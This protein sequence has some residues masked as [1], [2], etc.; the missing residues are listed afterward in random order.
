MQIFGINNYTYTPSCTPTAFKGHSR[1]LEKVLDKVVNKNQISESEK[2]LII[3]KI[4]AALCD[5][6]SASR[7]IGEGSHNA[8]YKI[9][10]KYAARIPLNEKIIKFNTGS[11]SV[12]GE[13]KFTKLTNFFGEAILNLGNLQIL[14]NVSPHMPAGVPEHIAKKCGRQKV[15][16]YYI[17]K[18]LPKF[19]NIS[20][21]SYNELAMN[22]AEL[23]NMKFGPRSYGLFDSDNPN[24]IVAHERRLMLVD[25]IYTLYDKPYANTTARLLNVFINKASKDYEAPQ[26]DNKIKLVKKIF[27]KVVTSGVYADLI[28]ADSKEDYTYWEKALKKCKINIPAYVVLEELESISRQELSRGE[29]ARKAA[30]Y[31]SALTGLYHTNK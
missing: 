8:V 27:K 13:V 12:R 17:N 16:Q 24:N 21:H 25:D 23:N 22:L 4:K 19:S 29:K 7:F 5:I 15:E 3:E 20:Q 30:A 26:T 14:K 10:K 18:Y 31:L 11:S 1:Q 28:H 6:F 2:N 9:T